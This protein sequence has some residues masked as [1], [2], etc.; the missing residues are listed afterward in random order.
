MANAE[1]GAMS[2]D[3][4]RAFQHGKVEG[5][6]TEVTESLQDWLQEKWENNCRYG[7]SSIQIFTEI[8]EKFYQLG[9]KAKE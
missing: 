9:K 3:K 5:V 2:K 8:A 1:G 7:E 4:G 6:S